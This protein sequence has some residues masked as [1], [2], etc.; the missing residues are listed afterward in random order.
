MDFSVI[1]RVASPSNESYIFE[2][3]PHYCIVP[4]LCEMG[5]SPYDRGLRWSRSEKQ[6]NETDMNRYKTIATSFREI[7]RDAGGI[8]LT[9][10]VSSSIAVC[11]GASEWD[12]GESSLFDDFESETL[13]SVWELRIGR[14]Q[15]SARVTAVDGRLNMSIGALENNP[16]VWIKH[17]SKSFMIETG[18]TLEFRVDLIGSNQEGAMAGLAFTLDGDSG[19]SRGYGL[20]FDRRTI[21]VSKTN[22]QA[23]VLENGAFPTGDV[24]MILRMTGSGDSVLLDVKLVDLDASR[25]LVERS[26]RDTDAVDAM[27]LGTDSPPA[28]F[29]GLPGRLDLTLWHRSSAP[30]TGNGL[31][32]EVVFDNA[33][34]F[35]HD[36]PALCIVRAVQ[37]TWPVTGIEYILESSPVPEGPWEAVPGPVVEESGISSVTVPAPLL[38][39]GRLF[40]LRSV[41]RP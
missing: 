1:S 40:R 10:I 17:G 9:T 30:S 37:L 3:L 25:V 35:E 39:V 38:P 34:V 26:V 32:S 36:S 15:G 12:T 33:T 11:Q 28:S 4:I 29:L 6:S 16:V 22:N 18:K 19:D 27:Q 8:I 23:F 7:L 21:V 41:I 31:P 14:D 2:S 5:S 13:D 24:R 20:Y